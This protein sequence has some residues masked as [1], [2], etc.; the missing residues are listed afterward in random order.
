MLFEADGAAGREHAQRIIQIQPN[1]NVAN[2][3][4]D[5]ERGGNDGGRVN[6]QSSRRGNLHADASEIQRQSN[7][8]AG[9]EHGKFCRATN[10]D[11]AAGRERHSRLP[12]VHGDDASVGNEKAGELPIG[13]PIRQT[14]ISEVG[15]ARA[16]FD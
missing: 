8:A 14:A 4:A 3:S 10:V 13:S 5:I 9:F 12:H 15:R 11:L 1:G 7:C 16:A 2:R 6:A